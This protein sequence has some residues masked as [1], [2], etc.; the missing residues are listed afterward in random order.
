MLLSVIM[1]TILAVIILPGIN[2][3][4]CRTEGNI[5]SIDESTGIK[6]IM[7]VS[8]FLHHFS[9]WIVPQTPIIYFFS[10]CGSFMVSVF[11][12]LSGYGL[13]KST[14]NKI[15]NKS[16]LIKRLIKIFIPY[17][18]CEIIYICFNKFLSVGDDIDLNFKNIFLSVLTL[19]EVVY[20]S[21]YVT[22]TIFLYLVFFFTSKTKKLDHTLCVFIVLALAF[23]FVPDL[24]TTFFA[25]PLGMLISQKENI[26]VKLNNKKYFLVLASAILLTAIAI[27]PKYIGQSLNNQI[28]MNLSDAASGSFFAFVVFL[29]VTKVKIGNK[30]LLFLGKISYEFYLL[31][32]LM[33][34]FINKFVGI[35]KPVVFC[36]ISLASIIVLSTIVNIVQ[37]KIITFTSKKLS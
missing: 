30:V 25:F 37:K 21:W 17:W 7:C 22:A 9:G 12:F 18:I 32:G 28:L 1:V 27:V 24:W 2:K 6:G 31:H 15:L 4:A 23:A 8:I 5:I 26:F 13:K 16:F 33:I 20:F 29:I 11:F 3:K 14:N 10:H 35:E 36:L 34:F 19:R